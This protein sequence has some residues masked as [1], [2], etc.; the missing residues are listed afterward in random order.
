MKNNI[1]PFLLNVLKLPDN[2]KKQYSHDIIDEKNDNNVSNIKNNDI[3]FF[4][5]KILAID[6]LKNIYKI[7]NIESFKL[8]IDN[9]LLN[10][11]IK[12]KKYLSK[13]TIKR[14]I[15]YFYYGHHI[16]INKNKILFSN[17]IKKIIK[18]MYNIDIEENHI[19][20]ELNNYEKNVIIDNYNL[21]LI[22]VIIS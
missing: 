8:W 9:N 18:K 10:I 1:Q 21:D 22:D 3:D 17:I 11:K 19:V 13:N 4:G 20:I 15:N 7:Y 12:R 2:N 14:I 5:Y 16:E 6:L